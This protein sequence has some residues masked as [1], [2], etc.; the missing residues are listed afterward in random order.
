MMSVIGTALPPTSPPSLSVGEPG[1]QPILFLFVLRHLHP[2]SC[3]TTVLSILSHIWHMHAH[4]CT[5]ALWG[6]GWGSWT[7]C[8][9]GCIILM[10]LMIESWLLVS[11]LKKWKETNAIPF[12]RW[13]TQ[14]SGR[15]RA[16]TQ[17]SRVDSNTLALLFTWPFTVSIFVS[18][19]PECVYHYFFH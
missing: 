16:Q 17:R 10:I 6:G 13:E 19:L 15:L 18:S 8:S 3:L 11:V 1:S 5:K 14:G 12:S 4:T 2:S 7:Y 9:E